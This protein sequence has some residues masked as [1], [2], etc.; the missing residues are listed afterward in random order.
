MDAEFRAAVAGWL[1]L[2]VRS[3]LFLVGGVLV[4]AALTEIFV[5]GTWFVRG[6]T[7]AETFE[8]S[9]VLLLLLGLA[10]TV[11]PLAFAF[12]DAVREARKGRI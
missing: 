6:E 4:L 1:W 5:G 11:P 7:F 9:A 10:M 12:R 2:G 3:F 8:Q